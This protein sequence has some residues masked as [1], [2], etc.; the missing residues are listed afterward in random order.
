[1][2]NRDVQ[3][4]RPPLAIPPPARAARAV[5]YRALRRACCRLVISGDSRCSLCYFFFHLFILSFELD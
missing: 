2:K 1:V 3:G 5:R 4:V